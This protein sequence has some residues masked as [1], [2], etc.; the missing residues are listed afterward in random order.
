MSEARDEFYIGYF[1]RAP[2]E[3]GTWVRRRLVILL[4]LVAAVALTLVVTMSPFSAAIFEYGTERTFE[5]TLRA[6]PAPALEVER[7]GVGD[8]GVSLYLLSVFGK[9]GAGDETAGLDGEYVRLE[10]TL[11]YRDGRAMIEIVSGTIEVLDEPA[12]SASEEQDLGVET[13]VGEIVDSKCFLGVMKPG[14]LK[15]HRACAVRCI[16]GGIPPVLAVRDDL[17]NVSYLFL[18]SEDGGAVNQEVLDKVAEP[19]SITGRVVRRD[20]LLFLHTDPA[21][22]RRLE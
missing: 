13:L 19:V 4:G 22:I 9:R 12:R 10:G 15:T 2:A 6:G 20:D 14:S 16:S 5:G 21:T 3:L 17:G 8:A 11:V 18:V 1:E 7:P